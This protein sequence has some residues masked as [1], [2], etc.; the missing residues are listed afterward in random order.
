MYINSSASELHKSH[1]SVS[2]IVVWHCPTLHP[3]SDQLLA[4]WVP[5]Q[6]IIVACMHHLVRHPPASLLQGNHQLMRV[7]VLIH[8]HSFLQVVWSQPSFLQ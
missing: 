4:A 1:A 2:P 7:A 6:S 5:L 3:S 8:P